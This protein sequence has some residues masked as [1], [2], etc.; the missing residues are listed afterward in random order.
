M[1]VISV[2]VSSLRRRVVRAWHS[3]SLRLA[4]RRVLDAQRDGR[5]PHALVE[6]VVGPG[7]RSA[8][9]IDHRCDDPAVKVGAVVGEVVAERQPDGDVVGLV[10]FEHDA[11]PAHERGAGHQVT[12]RLAAL[13]LLFSGQRLGHGGYATGLD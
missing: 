5:R 9:G 8:G 10:T 1:A 11:Q 6:V 4:A 13:V 2:K 3:R 7:G 12:H